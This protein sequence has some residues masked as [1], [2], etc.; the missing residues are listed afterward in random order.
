[1]NKTKCDIRR[2]VSEKNLQLLK[3]KFIFDKF[4]CFCYAKIDNRAIYHRIFSKMVEEEGVANDSSCDGD[5]D[6]I[7]AL[8]E[9]LIEMDVD[10]SDQV[11]ITS[12]EPVVTINEKDGIWSGY[13]FYS[14]GVMYAGRDTQSHDKI[15]TIRKTKQFAEKYQLP[16]VSSIDEDFVSIQKQT[17]KGKDVWIALSQTLNEKIN[18]FVGFDTQE[19]AV[20]WGN[21]FVKDFNQNTEGYAEFAPYFWH[22]KSETGCLVAKFPLSE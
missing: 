6:M 11:E 13:V 20:E 17:I 18:P 4:I 15:E 7:F 12:T 14:H 9:T 2:L 21:S 10:E 1:M 8:A 16:Y 5:D 19:Q 3:N 22:G